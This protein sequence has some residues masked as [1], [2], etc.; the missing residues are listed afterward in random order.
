MKLEK[1]NDALAV[2]HEFGLDGVDIAILGAIAEK[3]RG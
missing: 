1:L 2:A 3:R